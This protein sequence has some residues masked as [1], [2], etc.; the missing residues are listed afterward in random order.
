MKKILY[1]LTAVQPN[2]SG[3]MHGGGKYGIVVFKGENMQ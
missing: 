3:K 2:A 1:D